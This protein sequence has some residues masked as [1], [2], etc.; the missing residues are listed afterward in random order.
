MLNITKI[1][2]L[3]GQ[4]RVKLE[5]LDPNVQD[6][7]IKVATSADP[8]AL[9]TAHKRTADLLS[10]LT[11]GRSKANQVRAYGTKPQK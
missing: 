5:S 1:N 9:P 4:V 3:L 6:E 11:K 7:N 10:K 8:K 2:D